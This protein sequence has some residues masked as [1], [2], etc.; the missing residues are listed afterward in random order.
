MIAPATAAANRTSITR[1][2]RDLIGYS[3][4]LARESRE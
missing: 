4:A 1:R 3:K 2:T